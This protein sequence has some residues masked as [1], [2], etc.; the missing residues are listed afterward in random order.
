MKLYGYWRSSSSWR[1]R[2]ALLHKGIA[3][4]HQPV[5]LLRDGGEQFQPGFREKN[6]LS[7]VPVLEVEHEGRT[8]RLGQSMAI[9]DYLERV[10][11]SPSLLPADAWLAARS[12]QLAEIVNSGIQPLQNRALLERVR[13]AGEDAAG[14][15]RHFVSRGLAA[16]EALAPETAGDFLVG[17]A[18][19]VADVYLIPQLYNARRFGLDPAAYPTLAAVEGRC[20]ALPAFTE[21]HPDRQPDAE[22]A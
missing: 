15:A 12:R 7:E 13:D 21:S 22:K 11:P 2:I 19:S 8:R 6:P 20:L 9:L 1:V 17:D 16:L 3:C 5:H 14:W 4:T 18:V 10:Q